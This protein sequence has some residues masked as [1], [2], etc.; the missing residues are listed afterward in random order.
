MLKLQMKQQTY[1]ISNTFTIC[2]NFFIQEFKQSWWEKLVV[3]DIGL[4]WRAGSSRGL[5]LTDS[6]HLPE[7]CID[8]IISFS[9]SLGRLDPVMHST[10][11]KA[12][13]K[14]VS[15]KEQQSN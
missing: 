13:T 15:N 9:F 10:K 7:V 12:K 6:Q 1:P 5:G 14:I 8:S 11:L 4:L 3:L 2:I